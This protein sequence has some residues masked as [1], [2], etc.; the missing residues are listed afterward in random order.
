[1]V[2]DIWNVIVRLNQMHKRNWDFNPITPEW[3]WT[4]K[5]AY[6]MKDVLLKNNGFKIVSNIAE[7]LDGKDARGKNISEYLTIDDMLY[8]KYAFITSVDVQRIFLQYKY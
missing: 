1:M 4:N 2:G 3:N 5:L 6:K 8:F 7:I